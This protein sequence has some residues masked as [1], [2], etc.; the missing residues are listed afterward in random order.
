MTDEPVL[1]PASPAAQP[2]LRSTRDARFGGVC[3]GIARRQHLDPVLMRVLFVLLG[4]SAGIGF[5]LYAAA[6]AF[7]GDD[8]GARPP[9]EQW[10][11]ASRTWT[12]QRKW[13]TTAIV[14]LVCMSTLGTALPFTLGPAL[15][16]LVA[17]RVARRQ[18]ERPSEVARVDAPVAVAQA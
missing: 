3:S 9:M 8:T 15:V 6:Y 14:A 5:V 7:W 2:W 12:T 13:V 1:V 11:P 17:W 4:L 18:A 10:L 16:V